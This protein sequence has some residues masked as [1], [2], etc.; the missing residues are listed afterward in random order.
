MPPPR[1][2]GWVGPAGLCS[3]SYH[4]AEALDWMVVKV[5]ITKLRKDLLRLVARA[6]GGESLEFVHKGI[7]FKV[8]P[9]G[10]ASKFEKLK[11][12]KVVSPSLDLKK[13]SRILL[14]EIEAEWEK[15]WSEL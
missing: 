8:V 4:G 12:E 15:D 14:N 11:G 9:E 13:S 1:P 5:T 2:A 10:A 7:V 3:R 6:A